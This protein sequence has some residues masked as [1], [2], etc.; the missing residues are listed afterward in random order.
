M[1]EW[2]NIV[3]AQRAHDDIHKEWSEKTIIDYDLSYIICARNNKLRIRQYKNF[4]IY[5]TN[6]YYLTNVT[7]ES[8]LLF[9]KF[10]R[11]VEILLQNEDIEKKEI[12]KSA[13]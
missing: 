1:N 8:N 4:L 11:K 5:L 7:D 9:K 6:H 3:V 2:I 12:A 13:K 10:S